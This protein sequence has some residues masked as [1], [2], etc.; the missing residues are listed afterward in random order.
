MSEREAA[1]K[2]AA[3]DAPVEVSIEEMR[4]GLGDLVNRA[5]VGRERFIVT[6]HGRPEAALVSIKDL[7]ALVA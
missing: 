3:S 4:A 5:G 2:P 1:V 7:E 6:R